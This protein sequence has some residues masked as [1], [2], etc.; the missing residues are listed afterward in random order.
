MTIRI[1]AQLAVIAGSAFVAAMA[2]AAPTSAQNAPGVDI[3][4]QKSCILYPANGPTAIRCRIDVGNIGTVASTAP[5]TIVDT[6]TGPAGTTYLGSANSSFPCTTP[7]GALPATINCGANLSLMPGAPMAGSSS[8]S[9]F[10]DFRLPNTGGTFR[11]CARASGAQSPGTPGEANLQNNQSCVAITVPPAVLPAPDLSATKLCTKGVARSV[12]CTITIRNNG[13][14]ISGPITVTDTLMGPL[15]GIR[16][17][18][19]GGSSGVTCGAA[20]NPYVTPITCTLP[21]IP[22]GQNRTVIL[23]FWVPS[24]GSFSNAVSVGQSGMGGET[25]VLNNGT[26]VP[27][28]MP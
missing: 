16:Y 25:N 3:Q 4:V 10:I 13:T 11:N 5:L 15:P 28:I 17:T 12:T 14:T 18:G 26:I 6:P 7:T 2:A 9:T 24:N 8:G 20:Q 27:V 23:S 21:P 22:G 19:A 1:H